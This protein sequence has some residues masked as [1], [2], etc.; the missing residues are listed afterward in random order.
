[1]PR[2]QYRKPADEAFQDLVRAI[3]Q[4]GFVTSSSQL[5]GTVTGQVTVG[6]FNAGY[7][8][9]T[10]RVS[11]IE[12]GS[13]SC[14]LEAEAVAGLDNVPVPEA[15]DL[16]VKALDDPTYNRHK[17]SGC[18]PSVLLLGIL[19]GVAWYWVA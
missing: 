12:T 17:S 4:I 19:L 13:G 10:L 9:A 3:G 15:I 2:I 14:L 16:L 18:L 5:T 8:D 1:M 7:A 11:V 6:N